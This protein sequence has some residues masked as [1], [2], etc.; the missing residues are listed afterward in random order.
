MFTN[1][2]SKKQPKHFYRNSYKTVNQTKRDW[3]MSLCFAFTCIAQATHDCLHH[4]LI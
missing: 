1:D 4:E 3:F 2:Y